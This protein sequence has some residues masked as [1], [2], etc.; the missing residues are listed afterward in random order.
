MAGSYIPAM[1]WSPLQQLG[2]TIVGNLQAGQK[3]QLLSQLGQQFGSGDIKGA[4]Q[5]ALQSGD[6]QTAMSLFALGQQQEA[7]K[8]AQGIVNGQTT[9][10]GSWLTPAPGDLGAFNGAVK[11]TLGFEGGLNPRDTNG[12]PTNFGINQKANPDV[13]VRGLDQA[14][15][16]ALYKSRYW[17][18]IGGDQ[19]QQQ[20]PALA[21]VAFDTAVIAGPEK[22]K[23]LIQQSGGDP[24]KLLD[25]REQF[26]SSLIKSDPQKYGPYAQAWAN[27]NQGLRSDIAGRPV[28]VADASGA[29]P[30]SAGAQ[31]GSPQSGGD[32]TAG[33][34][35]R[36][37]NLMRAAAVP[38]L[39]AERRKQYEMEAEYLKWQ[40]SRADKEAARSP[41]ALS[42]GQ[43][44]V[45]PRTGRQIATGGSKNDVARQNAQREAEAT[46][47]GLQGEDRTQYIVNGRVATGVE[48]QTGEQANAATFAT[49]MSE[50]DKIISDPAI[51]GS[52]MGASGALR[53]IASSVPVVGNMAIGATEGGAAYQKFDQAKRDFV[54]AVLRK[55]SG[56]AISSSEFANAE[57]QYF[58]RP[59]DTPEVIAQKAKNRATAIDTIA[60]AGGPT[61][62]KEFAEK[63][64]GDTLKA[65]S[66]DI[67]AQA[68]DAIARG[69]PR[70]AIV[71]RLRQNGL[72]A[73]GL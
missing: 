29:V 12:T 35:A 62:R 10:S 48:K 9:Q 21:R 61:F 73:S 3:Q 26:Q 59:G 58:P 42:E 1:D 5:T 47:L 31:G 55:E 57:K 46:R 50:A 45:D 24:N 6:M 13:N 53:D 56:A 49:R 52:G 23:Q 25:L 14:G 43:I 27:R 54:N 4:A 72:D 16:T 69:A 41:V 2:Q 70:D 65:A 51:Y 66:P 11:R 63:R 60:N 17:D 18:A 39:S 30:A 33:L 8:T 28:Q 37:D 15:A 67:L 40:I 32:A 20:N 38:Y 64:S 68:R 34:M 36:V 71:Q 19:L 44:L 7:G 22:A